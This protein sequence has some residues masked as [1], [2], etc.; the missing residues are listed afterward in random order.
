MTENYIDRTL[1]GSEDLWKGLQSLAACKDY[2]DL[3]LLA[4]A[5]IVQS[6]RLGSSDAVRAALG[7]FEPANLEI[8]SLPQ[9]TQRNFGKTNDS[10]EQ[11]Q[12]AVDA[13]PDYGS[14]APTGFMADNMLPSLRGRFKDG[15]ASRRSEEPGSKSLPG[16][17]AGGGVSARS[18]PAP[19]R[20][21]L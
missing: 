19:K 3:A 10:W 17:F 8:S 14:S 16:R 20:T 6:M 11:L 18:A 9:Y 12:K 13:L 4:G 15:S 21:K 7:S 2:R 1:A 5:R